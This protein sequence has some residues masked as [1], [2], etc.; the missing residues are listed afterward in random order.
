ME[1]RAPKPESELPC[2]EGGTRH[3][4]GCPHKTETEKVKE[5]KCEC[6]CHPAK[7]IKEAALQ[8]M[9]YTKSFTNHDR[10]T[11]TKEQWQVEYI[12]LLEGSLRTLS[13]HRAILA[14]VL[15]VLAVIKILK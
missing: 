14:I 1:K 12:E 2:D 10:S 11:F 9:A 5:I 3:I 15:V 13:R 7:Q 8:S 6:L 4:K